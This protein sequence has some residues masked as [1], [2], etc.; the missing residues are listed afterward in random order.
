MTK[1]QALAVAIFH[2]C[3]GDLSTQLTER[4]IT[5]IAWKHF[6][7]HFCIKGHPE[8]PDTK[9]VSVL[10]SAASRAFPSIKCNGWL[11]KASKGRWQ[12]TWE[13]SEEATRVIESLNPL[14]RE[15]PG[16]PA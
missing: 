7:D 2:E 10:L 12:L 3:G 15:L 4:E 16:P 6:P 9:L 5:M 1:R 8:H 14:A 11:K 13:G